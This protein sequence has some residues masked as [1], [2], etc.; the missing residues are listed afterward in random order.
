M[1]TLFSIIVLVDLYVKYQRYLPYFAGFVVALVI[2]FIVRRRNR[3]KEA[4]ALQAQHERVRAELARKAELERQAAQ[5][6]EASRRAA[7]AM[8]AYTS[9]YTPAS[10]YMGYVLAY[11][12]ADVEFYV[13]PE[14]YARASAVPPHES[15]SIAPDPTNAHDPDAWAIYHDSRVIGYMFKGKLRD[16]VRDY[17]SDDKKAFMAVSQLWRDNK[18][19]MGL[20]FY[21]SSASVIHSMALDESARE[22][23]LTSN[24]GA[25]AQEIICYCEVGEPVAVEYDDETER[26]SAETSYG[27]I[28]LFPASAARFLDGHTSFDARISEIEEDEDAGKYSARVIVIP[29][30]K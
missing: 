24:R 20:Y 8:A 11:S 16:M 2:V 26:Y 30:G 7:S 25:E 6:A 21:K 27:R 4:A 17:A 1:S 14:Y 13:P 22:F 10:T 23:L 18:P 12:Y 9:E 29:G 3:R 15:L 5:K 19:T 28:G